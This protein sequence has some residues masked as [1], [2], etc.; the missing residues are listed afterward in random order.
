MNEIKSN[1]FLY[2]GDYNPEQWLDYDNII[3]Q[4]FEIFL[5]TSINT[6]SLGMFSWSKLEPEEGKY[7]FEWLDNIFDRVEQMHGYIILATP[8][9]SRPAW[10][11]EKYPEVLRVNEDRVRRRFGGRHNHCLSSK[12]YREKIKNI[13]EKLA[14]RYGKRECLILWHISNEYS[15]ECFCDNCQKKFRLWLQKKYGSLKNLNHAWWNDFW[16]H[17]Y[18]SWNQVFPPSYKSELGCKGMN[19]DWRRFITDITIDFLENEVKPLR[20]ITPNIPVTT[21]MMAF[22]PNM[23]PFTGLNYHKMSKKLDVIS[24]DAYPNWNN[25]Y[26]SLEELAINMGLIND[27]YRSLKKQNFLIMESTPSRVNWQKINKSKQPGINLLSSMQCIAHGSDSILYFQLRQSR[28]GAEMFHGAVIEHI[29][30]TEKRVFKEVS[31]LGE[32]LK[33]ISEIKG[34]TYEKAKVAIIFDCENYWALEDVE[35]FSKDATRYWEYIRECYSFFWKKDIPVDIISDQ[36]DFSEYKL[37]IDPMHFSMKRSVA[38]ELKKYVENGGTLIGS[39]I[40]GIVDENSLAYIDEIRDDIPKFLYGI[41]VNEIDV[42]YKEEYNV[43]EYHHV[44]YKILNCCT[45][46]KLAGAKS[47]ANYK[48]AFYKDTPAIASYK[49]GRGY[50]YFIGCHVEQRCIEKILNDIID[51]LNICSNH[52]GLFNKKESCISIQK[53]N[54]QEKDFYFLMNFSDDSKEIEI[55][56]NCSLYDYIDGKSIIDKSILLK[57]LDVKILKKE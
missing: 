12:I 25:D 18:S 50:S 20:T 36:D 28:G 41:K 54:F 45:V 53:R 32:K 5:K 35:G 56:E 40:Y 13:N 43:L 16:G 38:H 57:P 22:N 55:Q 1:Q 24:W 23:V 14:L 44:D 2:G 39:Y 46:M 7:D 51:N 11:A 27:Y 10:M 26:Q 31:E 37:L 42:L 17:T 4:D 29:R 21:N 9:G 8:S 3:D 30:A 15:G 33:L 6:V 49:L 19:L 52:D 34:S 47:L 48:K